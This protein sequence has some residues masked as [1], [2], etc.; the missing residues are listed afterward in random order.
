MENSS[1][2]HFRKGA[3]VVVSK[4]TAIMSFRPTLKIQQ[5][6]LSEL[7][8]EAQ[9]PKSERKTKSDIVNEL[10]ENAVSSSRQE[11]NE[12]PSEPSTGI[13]I[14]CPRQTVPVPYGDP[15][16]VWQ[17]PVDSSVCKGCSAYPC[18]SWENIFSEKNVHP[19][20]PI[21]QQIKKH[22]SLDKALQK[23]AFI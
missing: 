12:T 23:E 21:I 15:W 5:H 4:K 10:L 19:E 3:C 1:I 11:G 13:L 8:K 20:N 22:H 16:I 2:T 14:K 7:E 9:K 17:A 18:E 6:I